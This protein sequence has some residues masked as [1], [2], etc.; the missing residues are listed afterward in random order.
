VTG[1]E[2]LEGES[3]ADLWR[4]NG[5][6]VVGR[7]GQTFAVARHEVVASVSNRARNRVKCPADHAPASTDSR[8]EVGHCVAANEHRSVRSNGDNA[9]EVD[10]PCRRPGWHHRVVGR[11][12]EGSEVHRP[13]VVAFRCEV[14]TGVADA[15]GTVVEH[16]RRPLRFRRVRRGFAHLTMMVDL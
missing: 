1:L 3:V 14:H 16:P 10:V 2:G 7:L 13:L 12:V 11:A 6:G 9:V 15:A 4:E 8:K 5:T